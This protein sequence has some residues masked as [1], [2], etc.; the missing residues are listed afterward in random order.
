M[1]GMDFVY[2]FYLLQGEW[3]GPQYDLV[4]CVGLAAQLALVGHRGLK[5]G[6]HRV[7]ER[8]SDRF[9]SRGVPSGARRASK[10]P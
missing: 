3:I 7:G 9:R 6:I 8:L 1:L 4:L 2:A 10:V 5:N